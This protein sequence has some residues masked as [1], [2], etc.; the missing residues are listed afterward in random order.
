MYAIVDIETTGGQPSQDAIT[1]IA[2]IVH[3]GTQIV[4]QYSTLINPER[5]IP[6]FITQLTGISDEMVR[7]A[8]RFF[9]VAKKIVEMTENCIFVA[10]NARF[11][12]SFLKKQF[13]DFGYN[14]QRKTLCSV[15]LARKLIPGL[16]SYSLGKLCKSLNIELIDRH[17][18]LGDALATAKLFDLMLKIEDAEITE[19]AVK[20]EIKAGILPPAISKE[21]IAKLPD[22][23]GVYYFHDASGEVIYVGKSKNI[24]KRIIQ[25]FMVDYKQR[26]S[27]EFKNSIVDITYEITGCELVALLYESD[28]IKKMKP[29]YNR[30][31]RRSVFSAGIYM[32]E[33]EKGYLQLYQEK[34][35]EG[36]TPLIALNNQVHAKNFLYSKV[37]RYNLCQKL[38]DLYKTSTSCFDYQV[39]RCKGACV[40][41]ESPEEY[42]KRVK[43][44]VSSFTF[45]EEN[46]AIIG[47]GRVPGEKS[48]VLLEGGRYIGFGYADESFQAGCMDD[49]KQVIKPYRDNKDTQQIIKLY[50][51]QKHN[52]QVIRLKN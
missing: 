32:R 45:E 16:P 50:L 3:D 14:Y 30:Q 4:D 29:L 33:D 46:V 42:N 39:H 41:K 8:P 40:G 27:M 17:R 6:F 26:K 20:E 23:T 9:E 38:C 22:A 35:S 5:P 43:Q 13:N 24:R 49:F 31:Q 21:M 34:V 7:E 11:D 10:H 44:A 15:R 47:E 25:H 19:D 48:V 36:K 51:R 18:A 52:N 2:I 37:A 1:E 28:L 12:Y